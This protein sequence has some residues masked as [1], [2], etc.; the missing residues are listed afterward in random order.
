[1]KL[2]ARWIGSAA[3]WLICFDPILTALSPSG[4]HA[5]GV[6]GILA[7]AGIGW[8]F[9][10]EHRDVGAE[11]ALD[12]H[13]FFRR[14]HHGVAIEVILEAHAFLGDLAQFGERPDLKAAGVGEHGAIPSRESVKAAEFFD[15]L[16]ARSEPEVVGVSENNLGIEG[17]KVVGMKCLHRTLGAYG[18]ENGRLNHPVWSGEL[19]AT[20]FGI[21]IVGEEFEHA[22]TRS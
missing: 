18:H 7:V 8:A 1:M 13:A 9:V 6:L 15:D 10:K 11:D 14:Q 17:E 2:T 19:S 3:L 5:C 16:S 4:G 21:G 20:G 22:L 12:L